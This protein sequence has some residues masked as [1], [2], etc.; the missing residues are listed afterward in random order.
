MTITQLRY[1]LSICEF[2][3]IRTTSERLHVSE[4]TISIAIK[5]LEEE[6]GAHLFIR[7]KKQLTLTD[8]GIRLRD[9]AAEVVDSFDRLEAEIRQTR[10]KTPVIRLGTPST[11]GEYLCSRLFAEFMEKYPLV[12]FELLPLS[13]IEAARQVMDAK[14][15]LAVCDQLAVTSE[16]LVFSPIVH[17]VLFGYVRNDHPL[18]GKK[19]VTAQILKD[20]KLILL[21]EK[22]T[23]SREIIRWF[24]KAGAEPNLFMYSNRASFSVSMVKRYNAVTFFLGGLLSEKDHVLQFPP[25][26]RFELA[27]PLCFDI[28][29]VRKNGVKLTKEAQRF[30]DF[31]GNKNRA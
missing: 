30:F 15:E 16:Q 4:P 9:K 12:F 17:S 23:I 5:R 29:I 10:K 13:S 2:G 14:I 6:L 8:E 31:C 21:N 27:P 28:G 3:K 18:A 1:F 20:E 25:E 22:A 24:N 7:N 19:N 26:N 11:L